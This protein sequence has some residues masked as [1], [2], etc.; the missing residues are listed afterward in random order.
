MNIPFIHC[1]GTQLVIYSTTLPCK[2]SL[3]DVS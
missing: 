3:R 2:D 1:L